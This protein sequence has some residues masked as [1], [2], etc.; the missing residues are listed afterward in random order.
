MKW[1]VIAVDPGVSTGWSVGWVDTDE[2][3]E[4]GG[5]LAKLLTVGGLVWEAGEDN[6]LGPD[7]RFEGAD[8]YRMP[9]EEL[10]VAERESAARVW[11]VMD[12]VGPDLLVIED[13]TVYGGKAQE[14]ASGGAVP[15]A[16]VRVGSALAFAAE[17]GVMDVAYQMASLA[18]TTVTNERLKRWG[19][20]TKGSAHARDATRHLATYMRRYST[21]EVT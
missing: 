13:F 15:L 16:P 3:R 14:V 4:S 5:D 9:R 18:K 20:W 6:A 10:Y 1:T 8:P 19:L 21:G 2:L 7:G 11:E 12:E 17:L